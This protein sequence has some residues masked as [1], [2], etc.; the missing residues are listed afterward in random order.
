[1]KEFDAV[2][3][4]KDVKI[5]LERIAD[6]MIN[7]KKYQKL[8]VK[9]TRGLLLTGIPGVGKTLMANCLIKASKR[10]AFTIRKDIPEVELVKKIKETFEEARRQAPSI[11]FM[12][13]IDKFANSNGDRYNSE[14]HIT[15]QSCID[16]SKDCEVFVLAT[17]NDTA[18]MPRSLVR[19]GRFDKLINVSNPSKKDSE[20]II[21]Y[22]LSKKK[23]DKD[24][25]YLDIAR[26]LNGGTCA[27]LETVINEAGVY[28]GFENRTVVNR[29]DIIRS[30]K[31][32]M[33]EE[34]ESYDSIDPKHLK[35][36][37]IY[38]AGHA[39]IAEILEPDSVSLSLL[40]TR[41]CYYADSLTVFNQKGEG[42]YE[43]KTKKEN[44]I[45]FYL[46]GRAAHEITYGTICAD[47]NVADDIKYAFDICKEL[48]GIYCVYGFNYI[49]DNRNK[50]SALIER[51]T[52]L[53]QSEMERYYQQVKKILMD[54][55][56]FL[57][58]IAVELA[59]KKTLTY[60][61][62]Q[63]IKKGCKI[64]LAS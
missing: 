38:E 1:M 55:K 42:V 53:A 9:T 27:L 16:D 46:A 41:K 59:D 52:I 12:D 26:L 4:Y 54:N 49:A 64:S 56:D 8:G 39:A 30:Y 13:D 58:K 45:M 3:G 15:I 36:M 62:I 5:E 24:V 50:A 63:N 25:D 18:Y 7:P 47:T 51:Q 61:D 14:A 31:R 6:M 33:Y 43:D 35:A 22:Y 60:A 17:S 57:N 32:I 23:V 34:A 10:K 44:N 40:R 37:A 28:T 48:V 19:P 2:I 11:V 29:S 21:K 20:E